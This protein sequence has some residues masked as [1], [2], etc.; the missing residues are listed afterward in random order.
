MRDRSLTHSI[1]PRGWPCA[2]AMA[3]A[4]AALAVAVTGSDLVAAADSAVGGLAQ[5]DWLA[6]LRQLSWDASALAATDLILPVTAAAVAGLAL[7]RHWHGAITLA[8]SVLATQAVVHAVKTLVAR[9]RPDANGA[10]AEAAGHSFPSAHSATAVALY[11]TL[12]LLAAHRLEG[13]ARIAALVAGTAVV[14]AIGLSRVLLG[15]HYP[16]DV[17]A[18]WLTGGV[19]VLGSW[20]L[21]ARVFPRSRRASAAA[22]G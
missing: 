4:V 12:A 20:A 22:T 9:P 2:A 15:A 8:L 21:V 5:A 3:V 1:G 19:L 18:G 17:L 11:A 14:A 6:A 13:R 16:T 10:V 7:A